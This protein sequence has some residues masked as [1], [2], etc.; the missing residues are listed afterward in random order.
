MV[1]MPANNICQRCGEDH[2]STTMSRFN[3]DWICRYCEKTEKAHPKYKEAHDTELA[4]TKA[5]NYNFPGIGLPADF[6]H[7]AAIYRQ[8]LIFREHWSEENDAAAA[9]QG[10]GFF[11]VGSVGASCYELQ[12]ID[13]LKMFDSDEYVIIHIKDMVDCS[14]PLGLAAVEAVK[15]LNP[16]HAV[17]EGFMPNPNGEYLKGVQCPNCG[18]YREFSI[19]CTASFYVNDEVGAVSRHGDADWDEDSHIRCVECNHDGTVAEFSTEVSE[20]GE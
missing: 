7:W 9:K 20:G 12:R 11:D 8:N 6:H 5:K 16:E 2:G 1:D 18:Q 13:E 4:E 17:R 15:A 3:T 14:D 10:W 19:A